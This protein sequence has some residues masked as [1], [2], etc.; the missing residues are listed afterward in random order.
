M[1]RTERAAAAAA[2]ALLSFFCLHCA[3][4]MKGPGD[5]YIFFSLAPSTNTQKIIAASKPCLA[6][7]NPSFLFLNPAIAG[8]PLSLGAPRGEGWGEEEGEGASCHVVCQLSNRGL[9]AVS[10]SSEK[11]HPEL[12]KTADLAP[13]LQPPVTADGRV[14]CLLKSPSTVL[15]KCSMHGHLMLLFTVKKKIQK[16]FPVGRNPEQTG[17]LEDDPVL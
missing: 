12:Q 11:I 3:S 1:R 7:R 15:I 8:S 9:A 6:R 13:C 16:I 5:T 17:T 4:L 2:A 14:D 10:A